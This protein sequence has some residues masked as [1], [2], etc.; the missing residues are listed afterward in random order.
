MAVAVLAMGLI[1]LLGASNVVDRNAV[2]ISLA[3]TG[4]S[5]LADKSRRAGSGLVLGIVF[6]LAVILLYTTGE[7]L[8]RYFNEF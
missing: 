6:L 2:M 4:S 5:S 1:L 8:L 7:L 3:Y